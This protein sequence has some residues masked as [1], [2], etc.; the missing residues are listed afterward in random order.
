MSSSVDSTLNAQRILLEHIFLRNICMKIMIVRIHLE[1]GNLT[2]Q[3]WNS[4]QGCLVLNF[5]LGE[6]S[7]LNI[8]WTLWMGGCV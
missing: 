4:L 1:F 3:T 7:T 2:W 6:P 5:D 8:K